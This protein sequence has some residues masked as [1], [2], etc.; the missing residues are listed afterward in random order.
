[1]WMADPHVPGRHYVKHYLLDYGLSL[2]VMARVTQ[3]LRRSYEYYIDA[4]AALGGLASLGMQDRVWTKRHAPE[5]RGVG[6]LEAKGFSPGEW[7]PLS[8][9]YVPFVKADRFDN[10]WGAKLVMRFTRAQIRAA[11]ES[12]RFSDPRAVDYLTNALVAR[13]RA[14]G[15]YWFA[16]VNPLER[17]AMADDSTVCFDDLSLV[18][19]FARHERTAYSLRAYDRAGRSLGTPL[20][21]RAGANGRTCA[22][23]QLAADIDGYTIVR[24]DTTRPR[25]RGTTYVHLAREPATRRP[26]VVGIWRV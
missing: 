2:G 8:P 10:Y 22:R 1:M 4:G 24:I 13:Q 20:S 12:G 11:V 15:A 3:N 14:T 9:A 25:F 6:V 5:L 21:M 23:V 19:R 7:K 26:R 18:Y 17:F 16:R